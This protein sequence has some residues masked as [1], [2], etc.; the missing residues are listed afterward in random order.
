LDKLAT[1]ARV[2]LERRPDVVALQECVQGT[3]PVVTEQRGVP[4]RADN[5]AWL[6]TKLLADA[7]RPHDWFWDWAHLGW[8]R[9]EEGCALLSPH[10][11]SRTQ[12]RYVSRQASTETW[13]SRKP[14]AAQVD[15]PGFPSL[16]VVSAHLGWWADAEEPFSPMLDRLLAWQKEIAPAIPRLT[17]GD[18]NLAAGTEGYGHLMATTGWEDG[19]LTVHPGGM[20]DPTIGA[21]TEGWV[22]G[23]GERIDY[24][25]S[26]PGTLRPTGSWRLFTGTDADRVSDHLG[27]LTTYVLS[28]G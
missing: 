15:V 22:T 23:A 8:D 19:Y 9:W 25:F 1:V 27:V 2:I 4:I 11:L 6:L 12:A 5:Q 3:G 16:S 21:D 7:G 20:G 26:T 28:T 14:V 18:F 13:K 17:L 24:T 10:G